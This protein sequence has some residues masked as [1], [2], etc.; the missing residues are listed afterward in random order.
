MCN[1]KILSGMVHFLS[2]KADIWNLTVT[3]NVTNGKY[4]QKQKYKSN[5]VKNCFILL[6]IKKYIEG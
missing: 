4:H 6:L 2:F 3:V 1:L 5:Q